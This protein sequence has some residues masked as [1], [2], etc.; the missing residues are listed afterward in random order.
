MVLSKIKGAPF[1]VAGKGGIFSMA[2]RANFSACLEVVHSVSSFASV[3][4]GAISTRHLFG[5]RLRI[6][7]RFQMT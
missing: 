2:R 5:R 1:G 6:W 7:Y 4:L 3:P